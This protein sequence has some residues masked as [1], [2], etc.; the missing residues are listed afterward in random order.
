MDMIFSFLSKTP[1]ELQLLTARCVARISIR[2]KQ[3][4]E[5]ALEIEGC[6]YGMLS[7]YITS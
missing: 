4:R 3:A 6:V 2:Q 1:E 7:E 5:T